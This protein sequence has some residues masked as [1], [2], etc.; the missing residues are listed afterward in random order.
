[1]ELHLYVLIGGLRTVTLER[2][3]CTSTKVEQ[4]DEIIC[5]LEFVDLALGNQIQMTVAEY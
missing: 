4:E 2:M 1:M 5:I 3:D